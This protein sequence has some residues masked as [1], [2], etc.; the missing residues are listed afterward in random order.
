MHNYEIIHMQIIRNIFLHHSIYLLI[1][2][3]KCM[4]QDSL[5]M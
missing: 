1:S 2:N 4:G 5:I 3:T